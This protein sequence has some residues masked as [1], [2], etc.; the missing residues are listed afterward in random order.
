MQHIK[1]ILDRLLAGAA[2]LALGPVMLAAAIGIKLSDKGPVFYKAQR[3]GMGMA[4]YTMYKFRTMRVGSDKE[5][6][7][8]SSHDN[9][10]YLWGSFLRKTKI[11]EL[12]Q[13]INILTGTM[14]I[15]GPRPEDVRIVQEHY[16][17]DEL[18]T[19]KVLPGLACPGSIF[20]YTHGERLLEGGNADSLYVERLLH[21]KLALDLYYLDHW[22][23]L[24]DVKIIFRTLYTVLLTSLTPFRIGYPIEYRRV[25]GEQGREE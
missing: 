1:I 12:P 5:G 19:L 6:A 7:I 13:L 3:M 22:S 2:L 4:P 23:L 20:N 9:R 18:R 24:Y 25:F 17:M 16:S 8:T 21:V 11:D 10:V 14:S 15:V